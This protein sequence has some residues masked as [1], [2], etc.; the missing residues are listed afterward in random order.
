VSQV[1][2]SERHWSGRR[3]H[4]V[5]IGGSGMS[6]LA[7]VAAALGADISG[8]DRADGR[9]VQR[10]R[11]GGIEI[12][13]G[14]DA[15]NVPAGA[16][17]VYSSAVKPDN[18]ERARARELGLREIRR[19]ELLGELSTLRKCI[20]IAGTHG[21]S[22]TAAMTFHALRGAGEAPAFVIGAD[23]RDEGVNAAWTSGTWLVVETDESDRT[24]LAVDVDIGVL[25][26]VEFEHT[27]DYGSVLDLYEV[28]GRF[29]NAAREAVIWDRPE[30]L[31]LRDGP[32]VPFAAPEASL[33]PAGS[34]FSWRGIPVR[35]SVPGEHNVRNA[36]AALEACRLAGADPERAATALATFSG[37][38]RRLEYLGIT[39]SGA[40]IYD[41]YAHHPTEVLATL[42]AARTLKPRRLVVVFEPHLYTRTRLM[43]QQFGRSLAVADLIVVLRVFGGRERTEDYP[44]V[45][46]ER[47]ARATADAAAGRT[48]VWMP[49]I[50]AAQRYLDRCLRHG[51]LCVTI[52][53]G[54]V[55]ALAHRVL[56]AGLSREEPPLH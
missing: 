31:A 16:E 23:L 30:L 1:A 2:S 46:A 27:R 17:L 24:L 52:G 12:A 28:F 45:S 21:K 44:G 15:A 22:T 8:S 6:G 36:A 33:T 53:L 11:A 43:A 34:S 49:D 56:A 14:H 47:I 4:F 55:E 9:A 40:E 19:G 32:V 10:L 38:R 51:D 20:A 54:Q 26:N 39:R 48:V 42:C 37:A 18:P 29:V 5:G 7:F 50:D 3:L 41:D 35:L 13:V 25:T